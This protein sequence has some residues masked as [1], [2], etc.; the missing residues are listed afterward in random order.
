LWLLAAIVLVTVATLMTVLRYSLPYMD[1]QK[2]YFEDILQERYGVGLD[3]GSITASWKGVG[4]AIVLE[5]VAF[6]SDV[7][8]PV[9]VSI[10]KTEIEIEFWPSVLSRR[11]NASNFNLIGADVAINLDTIK[12]TESDVPV[13]DVLKRLFLEQLQLFS[14]TDST[15]SIKKGNNKQSIILQQLFWRNDGEIHQGTGIMRVLELANNSANFTLN[16]NG[17]SDQLEGTFFAR[18]R[19]LDIAPWLKNYL[20]EEKT[21]QQSRAN[22]VLWSTIKQSQIVATQISFEPSEFSW[23]DINSGENHSLMVKAGD[24]FASPD[25]TSR[26][27]GDWLFE[28]RDLM[29]QAQDGHNALIGIKGQSGHNSVTLELTDALD[30]NPLLPIASAFM[31]ESGYQKLKSADPK[32]TLNKILANRSGGEWGMQL[33]FDHLSVNSVGLAPGLNDISGEVTWL[34]KQ[35]RIDIESV[36][37]QLMTQGLLNRPLNY[38]L[39]SLNAY[40]DVSQPGVELYVPSVTL[41]SDTLSFEQSIRYTASNKWLSISGTIGDMPVSTAKS[42]LPVALMP[43]KTLK[44][45]D[46]ALVDGYIEDGRIIWNGALDQYPYAQSQGIFQASLNINEVEFDFDDKWPNI[47]DTNLAAMFENDSLSVSAPNATIRNVS[48]SNVSAVIPRLH[49]D[50]HVRIKAETTEL[51][52]D[53]T[54]LILN[55]SLSETLGNALT[56]LPIEN[57]IDTDIDLF[58]PL[59]GT[60]IVARGGIDFDQNQLTIKSA[61]IVLEQLS[62]RLLFENEK[63]IA[64]GLKAN[65][66]GLPTQFDIQADQVE[67]V[68]QVNADLEGA[69]PIKGLF[70]DQPEIAAYLDGLADWQGTLELAFPKNDFSYELQIQSELERISSEFPSPL[71]KEQQKAKRLLVSSDGNLLASN[72]NMTLG[73]D[74][75]FNGI[76][77]HKELVF[78]RAHLAIGNDNFVGMGIGFS[79]SVDVP[80]LNFMPWFDA[81]N[82]VLQPKTQPKRRYIEAPKR[83]FIKTDELNIAGFPMHQVEVNVRNT[84]LSWHAAINADETRAEVD[85]FHEW[86]SKGIDAKADYFFLTEKPDEIQNEG[87]SQLGKLLPPINFECEQC[88]IL[89]YDFGQADIKLE[90]TDSGMRIAQLQVNTKHATLNAEGDWFVS[91]EN[92]STRLKGDFVSDDFGDFLKEFDRDAGIRDS[93]AK[94]DFDLSWTDA[95]YAFE[96]ATLSGDVDWAL[97]DGNLSQISDK[98]ARIFSLLSLDSLVR[99]LSLDFRDVFAKGFFYNEMKGSFRANDGIVYTNDTKV[100]G[101]A[102]DIS[103]VGSTD[104]NTQELN[105]DVAIRPELT[106]SL[107]A[108]VGWLAFD[109]VSAAVAFAVDKAVKS[110]RVVSDIQ[111][112]LTGSISEPELLEIERNNKDIVLPAQVIPSEDVNPKTDHLL[113]E[114]G[115]G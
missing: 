93:G 98:G 113:I 111:Y 27:E 53:L 32:L 109:P 79:V 64:D 76:L 65:Y 22:F 74:I 12:R 26:Q 17:S 104:L 18:G 62:G 45:L 23:Q 24:L 2:E 21:L 108:I 52:D 70:K 6:K 50:S 29:V 38:D 11:L 61:G 15:L 73:D 51:G 44:Y 101:S 13:I 99:K 100:D 89:G 102:A 92:N 81:L 58:V 14:L 106:S 19:E 63:L 55:S 88:R 46:D 68:Y 69:W 85:F 96:L 67:D 94:M 42:L 57:S 16:V 1:Q 91:E 8:S 34:G 112:K 95:P 75:K 78:S 30:I 66:L 71:N 72:V 36:D 33:G 37:S 84:D 10:E 56:L 28:L 103:L 3:I 40:I 114:K 49:I 77:P 25:L 107:P 48:A 7:E 110:A 5:N 86:K 4:P 43:A 90:P 54:D 80:E 97:D 60:N 105:Y 115:D 83:I 59:R 20:H 35:G 41:L 39:L 82:E 9:Q 87:N 47:V 31:S